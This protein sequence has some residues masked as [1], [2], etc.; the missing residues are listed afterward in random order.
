M[1]NLKEM[2]ESL[3][4]FFSVLKFFKCTLR[5]FQ[6]QTRNIRHVIE[7]FLDDLY[8]NFKIYIKISKHWL[9]TSKTALEV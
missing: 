3:L 7:Y 2:F 1:N 9:I 4:D 6:S 5:I 8:E